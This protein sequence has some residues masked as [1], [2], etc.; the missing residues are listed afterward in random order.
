MPL[1]YHVIYE[2]FLVPLFPNSESR[3]SCVLC[4]VA[5]RVGSDFCFVEFPA[6]LSGGLLQIESK[7]LSMSTIHLPR[8]C[9]KAAT[10]PQF[11]HLCFDKNTISREF[12]FQIILL[13]YAIVHSF[14][15]ISSRIY[16]K[17]R[18]QDLGTLIAAELIQSTS[19]NA[20]L[21]MFQWSILLHFTE[22]NICR[23]WHLLI[24]SN[25][26]IISDLKSSSITLWVEVSYIFDIWVHLHL[27]KYATSTY[28]IS[29]IQLPDNPNSV[30]SES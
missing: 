11:W 13:I 20:M 29:S 24:I 19:T 28:R 5:E 9:S 25:P 3:K 2:C 14:F 18:C 22:Y 6:G 16:H 12:V 21:Q 15:L 27:A 1:H 7:T 10:V 26:I 17:Y 8:F 30:K 4:R 23:W